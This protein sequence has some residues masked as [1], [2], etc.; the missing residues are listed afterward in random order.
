MD[1][2]LDLFY[3]YI[4]EELKETIPENILG[5]ILLSTLN[6]LHYLKEKLEIIHRGTCE[7]LRVSY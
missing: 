7:E 2:S 1:T 3:K 6:A 4:Y 5:K